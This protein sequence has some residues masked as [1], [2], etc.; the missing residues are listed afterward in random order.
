M[1]FAASF[2]FTKYVKQISLLKLLHQNVKISMLYDNHVEQI[3]AICKTDYDHTNQDNLEIGWFLLSNLALFHI[4]G[5]VMVKNVWRGKI[6]FLH[7][8]M[9]FGFGHQI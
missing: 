2:I 5:L 7:Y 9:G 3:S 1:K 6:Q 8:I 4:L